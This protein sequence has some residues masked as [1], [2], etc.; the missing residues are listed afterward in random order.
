MSSQNFFLINLVLFTTSGKNIKICLKHY[1]IVSW[2]CS[3]VFSCWVSEACFIHHPWKEGRCL[4]CTSVKLDSSGVDQQTF[5]LLLLGLHSPIT[6]K[7]LMSCSK[8]ASPGTHLWWIFWSSFN[9]LFSSWPHSD[10]Q[11]A[12]LLPSFR[13][14][15][16]KKDKKGGCIW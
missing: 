4:F 3:D 9:Q 16:R 1:H 14:K 11:S 6:A 10:V 13:K 2:F 12:V 8:L 15:K 5:L 7:L